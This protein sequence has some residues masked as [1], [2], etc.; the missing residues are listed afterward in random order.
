MQGTAD[1]IPS[2]DMA[3]QYGIKTGTSSMERYNRNIQSD[4]GEHTYNNL[5]STSLFSEP[6][7][8]RDNFTDHSNI[9]QDL[10]INVSSL[11]LA[12]GI[13]NDMMHKLNDEL[14]KVKNERDAMANEI[15]MLR[16][17]IDG[18]RELLGR[19]LDD[20]FYNV[21][22]EVQERYERSKNILVFHVPDSE[23]ETPEMLH[24]VVV[25]L[26]KVLKY[27]YDFPEIKRLGN[28]RGMIRPI[29]MIFKSTD[30]VQMVLKHKTKLHS[31]EY[32]KNAWIGEDKTITQRLKFKSQPRQS[33]ETNG[34][35]EIQY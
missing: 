30:C 31:S 32:F 2:A 25:N 5:T 18:I 28:Y 9:I 34:N 14:V 15:K 10:Q 21:A 17:S 6:T 26:L 1:N 8:T 7:N 33:S 4:H 11:S 12:Y 35:N 3:D 16:V 29:R 27:R 13:F 20:G 22:A 19:K 24:A 23:D